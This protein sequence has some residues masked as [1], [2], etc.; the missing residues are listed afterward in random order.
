MSTIL[1]ILRDA[2][3]IT[4]LADSL[5][6]NFTAMKKGECSIK[7]HLFE[8]LGGKRLL[9]SR[10]LPE[11]PCKNTDKQPHAT[12]VSLS[13]LETLVC[14]C[15]EKIVHNNKI[16][17]ASPDVFL[18]IST[19]KGNIDFI[20]DIVTGKKNNSFLLSSF[21]AN[22]QSHFGFVHTPL[23]VSNACI[24]GTQAVLFGQRLIQS[25]KYRQI[26]V[27][28]G[29]LAGSFTLSGFESFKALSSKPCRPFDKDRDGI[30]IG[31]GAG[32]ILLDAASEGKKC[33]A[34]SGGRTTNDANH[35]SG[36]SRTGEELAECIRFA[37]STIPE[38]A[39]KPA[40]IQA[41]GTG[42]IYNDEME[43]KAYK[44]AGA[45]TCFV[46]SYKGYFG[47]TLGAAGIIETAILW[48]CMQ[49]NT[50]L[51][52]LGFSAD[53]TPVP[54]NIA[55][56]TISLIYTACL[57]TAAGFAGTNVCIGLYRTD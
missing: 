43:S 23:V 57:K 24:S 37:M 30:S 46:N 20:Q 5:D 14:R 17:T 29:D 8:D 22:I 45:D 32:A 18:I 12:G 19:T 36:P 54:L 42:T 15:I 26:I 34:V 33:I 47:H 1:T 10:V 35:I 6:G 55:R 44:T 49:T 31:D 40:V 2:E 41:H 3:I 50:V 21:A 52:T 53:G 11:T 39:G 51:K 48:K 16:N 27:A 13:F 38:Y 25:G 28:G 7:T 9:A 56:E 4:G